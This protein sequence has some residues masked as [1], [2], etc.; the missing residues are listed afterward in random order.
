VVSA[1][2]SLCLCADASDSLDYA[3]VLRRVAAHPDAPAIRPAAAYVEKFIVGA[4]A[5]GATERVVV[6]LAWCVSVRVSQACP[7]NS[8]IITA[9]CWS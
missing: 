2:A 3:L 6:L 1:R 4:P 7:S 8:P 9:S 5:A